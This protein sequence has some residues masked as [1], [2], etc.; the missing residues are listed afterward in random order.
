MKALSLWQPWAT[1]I[2][3]GSKRVETRSWATRHRG[4]IAIHAA[5]RLNRS[6]LISVGCSWTYCG[7][8]HATG[9]RMGDDKDLWD[10]LPFQAIV[11]TA[12]LVDVRPTGS[13]RGDEIDVR[14]R[15]F[16]ATE[17]L[18]WTER[19]MGNFELGRFG[20]VLENVVQLPE[21]IP[22]P[23]ARGLWDWERP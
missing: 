2:A 5:K 6:E 7:A 12:E 9:K 4:P 3:V 13:F 17:I 18:E 22:C 21:P 1:L 20:W 8:L 14:R 11:A 23:G 16:G 19:H 15:P 10:L